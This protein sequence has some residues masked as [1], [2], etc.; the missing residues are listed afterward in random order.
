MSQAARP[1]PPIFPYIEADHV[2][3]AADHTGRRGRERPDHDKQL[4]LNSK[5]KD[6]S[7]F[8]SSHS[9]PWLSRF[10]GLAEPRMRL[11]VSTK[12]AERA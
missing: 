3:D 5:V 2:R 6:L 1:S 8:R 11:E 9:P 12:E 4:L 7:P 10:G